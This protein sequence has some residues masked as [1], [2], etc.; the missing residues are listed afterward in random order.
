MWSN[1]WNWL[2]G[3]VTAQLPHLTFTLY[4]RHGCHLCDEARIQLER[5]QRRY[6]FRLELTDIDTS[7][8]LRQRYGELVPVVCVNGKV[9]FK[10]GVNRVLLR[11]LLEAEGG[12]TLTSRP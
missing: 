10:G 2:R 6:G 11:R 3:G 1:L 12:R 9:R 7:A 4:T 5:E 8:D